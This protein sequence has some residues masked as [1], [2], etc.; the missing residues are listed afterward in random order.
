L[1]VGNV[2]WDLGTYLPPTHF[3]YGACPPTTGSASN[4]GTS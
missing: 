2:C 3:R 4:S 1:E